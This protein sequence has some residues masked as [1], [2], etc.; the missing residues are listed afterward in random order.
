MKYMSKKMN[1]YIIFFNII[2]NVLN[3]YIKGIKIR[4]EIINIY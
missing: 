4:V 3:I 2:V 1:I